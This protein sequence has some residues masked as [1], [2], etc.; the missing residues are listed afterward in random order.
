M[1]RI[2]S[3]TLAL[4]MLLALCAC[5]SGSSGASAPAADEGKPSTITVGMTRGVETVDVMVT[6]SSPAILCCY[7]GLFMYNPDSGELEPWLAESYEFLSDTQ[8][9]IKLHEGVKFSNGEELTAEDV[10]YSYQ[11]LADPDNGFSQA[12]YYQIFDFDNC[13]AEDDYTVVLTT[14]SVVGPLINYLGRIADIVNKDYFENISDED[15]WDHTCGTGPYVETENISGD[16]TTLQLRDDY[17]KADAYPEVQTLILRSYSEVLT[18]YADFVNGDLDVILGLDD[19][20][21]GTVTTDLPTATART[22]NE[23]ELCYLTLP[24]YVEAFSDVRVR[25]AI[26]EAVDW[27]VVI[28]NAVG[29]LGVP[30]TSNLSS[31]AAPFYKNEGAYPFDPDHAKAL[32]AEAGYGG[33]LTLNVTATNSAMSVAAYETIQYYLAQVGIDLQ[34]ETLESGSAMP[35]IATGQ[36][37]MFLLESANT[38]VAEPALLMQHANADSGLAP[39]KILDEDYNALWNAAFS[40]TDEAERIEL[41]NQIQD[42]LWANYRHIPI[43]EY[44]SAY[45]YNDNISELNIVGN[46]CANMRFIHLA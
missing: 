17:W 12:F 42:W 18:M 15:L 2:L 30:A 40:T 7:E 45:A 26:A 29:A 23:L 32:L 33:G 1:K 19:A 37:D 24:S 41:Y 16:H 5:G 39:C 10:I 21:Y 36:T 9:R 4:V 20:T 31:T 8:I 28:D 14:Y 46:W 11:R 43:M 25:Q 3:I 35:L 34:Y 27:S 22:A 13:Y 38:P 44:I 6:G